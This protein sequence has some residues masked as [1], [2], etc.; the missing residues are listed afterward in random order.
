MKDNFSSTPEKKLKKV[1]SILKR[2][3]GMVIKPDA[4]LNTLKSMK[5]NVMRSIDNLKISGRVSN[6]DP[7]LSKNLLILE[8]VKAVIEKHQ[9]NEY[10]GHMA[11]RFGK[12]VDWLVDYVYKNIELGDDFEEA[13]AEGMKQYRSSKY[14]FDDLDV[15]T[16]VR[17]R[18]MQALKKN[19]MDEGGMPMLDLEFNEAD[20]WSTGA[21]KVQDKGQLDP[22]IM[23]NIQSKHAQRK[24]G[25]SKV[26]E[27]KRNYV[28]ELRKLLEDEAVDQA[29]VLVAA[30]GFSGEL[31][32]IIQKIGRMQ[33]EDLS[34]VVDQMRQAYGADTAMQFQQSMHGELDQIISELRNAKGQI[35]QAVD[36]MA[37]GGGSMDA[38]PMGV[39]PMAD[40]S[41][42]DELG[43]DDGMGDG[44]DDGMG[45][46]MD[47]MAGD[48]MGGA[49][50][51][52]MGDEP[53]GRMAKE[54]K[55]SRLEKQIL[56]MQRT[57]NEMK[58]LKESKRKK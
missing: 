38:E 6:R 40:P 45:D 34:P 29:E 56:E 30:K 17:S 25:E 33:N 39:D 18:V 14:R 51:A 10:D 24:M 8:G 50:A 32:D 20:P 41:M 43:M 15:Q 1:N 2:Q 7:E 31:Q 12:V 23:A 19:H 26:K 13:M 37:S 11:Q 53:L 22:A 16:Q 21:E 47:P 35:D 58:R 46:P 9:L 4:D 48:D 52:A 44:M 49:D 54:S 3:F 5:E 27:M 28:K 36:G 55:Q 42:G 57:V